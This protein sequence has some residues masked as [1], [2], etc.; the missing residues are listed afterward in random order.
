TLRAA[1]DADELD[2]VR[3][4]QR[5]GESVWLVHSQVKHRG[6]LY[7]F[8]QVELHDVGQLERVLD[9]LLVVPG[10]AQVDVVDAQAIAP[11]RFERAIDRVA[12]RL[13][14]LGERAKANG[15]RP[16]HQRFS[17]GVK[18]QMLP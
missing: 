14:T 6:Q 3:L 16:T 11:G 15:R 7:D 17:R 5:V 8:V 10:L 13:A 12:C 1:G 4:L 2:F 9:P 18:D